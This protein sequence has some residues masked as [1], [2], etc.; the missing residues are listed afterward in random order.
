MLT[1]CHHEVLNQE[2][3][4]GHPKKCRR[5]CT[6]VAVCNVADSITVTYAPLLQHNHRH[7]HH[8]SPLILLE[9]FCQLEV[10][11]HVPDLRL[12]RQIRSRLA[13]SVLHARTHNALAQC[14]R[15]RNN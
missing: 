9:V 8:P 5:I 7:T 6:S 11:E 4:L 15:D 13:I 12:C 14:M 3:Q 1:D 2:W 10:A